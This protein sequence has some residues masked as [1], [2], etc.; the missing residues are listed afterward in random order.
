MYSRRD[1]G[2]DDG[3][4]STTAKQHLL[5]PEEYSATDGYQ[6]ACRGDESLIHM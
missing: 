2:D 6:R 3:E 5:I 4:E 1:N